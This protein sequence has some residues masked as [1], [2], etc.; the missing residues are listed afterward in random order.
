MKFTYLVLLSAVNAVNLEGHHHKK[1]PELPA[2]PVGVENGPSPS[3]LYDQ[4]DHNKD[5]KL[6]RSE[7]HSGI[8]KA[9]MAKDK[10][11]DL[12]LT[13]EMNWN[14][15]AKDGSTIG[16]EQF[17]KLVNSKAQHPLDLFKTCDSNKDGSLSK[18]EATTCI[19]KK[20][21]AGKWRKM[22]H[23][24]LAQHWKEIDQDK[25]GKVSV[26]EIKQAMTPLK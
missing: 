13:M 9:L 15:K 26:K 22:F 18:K 17:L 7:I 11:V 12:H 14:G 5:G 16:K 1:A 24:T 2:G 19:D 10:K 20:I 4:L 3:E 23:E 25:N 21:R 8:D 6:S